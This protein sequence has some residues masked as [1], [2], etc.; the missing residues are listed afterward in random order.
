MNGISANL[1]TIDQALSAAASTPLDTRCFHGNTPA[2]DP[3][4]GSCAPGS[5]IEMVY[6]EVEGIRQRIRREE[7]IG[8]PSSCHLE[9]GANNI[10]T[11]TT[12]VGY[13]TTEPST[14]VPLV[15]TTSTPSTYPSFMFSF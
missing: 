13:T 9:T 11:T 8:V 5:N 14:S 7:G 15:V 10:P 1:N 2:P 12:E 6:A 4:L 3:L